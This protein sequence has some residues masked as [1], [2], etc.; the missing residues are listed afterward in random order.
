MLFSDEKGNNYHSL[1]TRGSATA[2][3]S[4]SE[5]V[6]VF[7]FLNRGLKTKIYKKNG[8]M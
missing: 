8:T 6:I 5:I 4:Y 2:N 7:S 3:K 1:N